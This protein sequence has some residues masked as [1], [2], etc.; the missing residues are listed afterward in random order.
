MLLLLL[1]FMVALILLMGDVLCRLGSSNATAAAAAAITEGLQVAREKEQVCRVVD[2][3]LRCTAQMHSS[4]ECEQFEAQGD[5]QASLPLHCSSRN[6]NQE[7]K[8]TCAR[9]PSCLPSPPTWRAAPSSPDGSKWA[10]SAVAAA[11]AWLPLVLGSLL[12]LFGFCLA[13]LPLLS[14][15]QAHV[16]PRVHFKPVW[17]GHALLLGGAT[18][19][20]F[21]RMVLSS[22]RWLC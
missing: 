15:L 2:A 8:H 12:L 14:L 10:L 19:W 6:P 21:C 11:P 13:F 22:Q 17:A 18:T 9:L 5:T 4:K 20:T 7:H 1:V 16:R 3:Q